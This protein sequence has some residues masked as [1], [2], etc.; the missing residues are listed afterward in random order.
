MQEFFQIYVF[1]IYKQQYKECYHYANSD[2]FSWRRN[3]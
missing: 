1:K 3:R 2:N